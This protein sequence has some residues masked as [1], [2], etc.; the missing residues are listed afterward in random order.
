MSYFQFLGRNVRWLFGGFLLT[1][2][3]SFGQTFFISLSGG[4]IRQE[5]GLSNGEWGLSYMAA[6]LASALTLPFFGRI[7]DV[8]SVSKTILIVVPALAL[9]CF[10]MGISQSILLLV[11]IIYAL[12][13]FGQGMLTHISMTAM[14]RWYSA[15][16]GRAVSVAVVGH[17]GGEALLPIVF[18]FA[19]IVMGW[20]DVWISSAVLLL[21]VALPLTYWLMRVER[22][23]SAGEHSNVNTRDARNWTRTEVLRDPLFYGLLVAVLAPSFIGTTLFFHQ[24]YLIEL[25]SWDKLQYSYSFTIMA[26]MTFIFALIAGQLVDRFSAIRLL[27]AFLIPLAASCFAMWAIEPIWGS[28]VF[29]ALMGVSYGF[30]S[31]LFGALWPEVYGTRHLGAIRAIT[32][33]FMVFGTALG[34][35]VTGYLIDF[36]ISYPLQIFVMGIYCLAASAIMLFVSRR[37]EQRK[38]AEQAA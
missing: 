26:F 2:F 12:R 35:G 18:V 8:L 29:M 3:S 17:Q 33:A 30:S 1:F 32:I 15:Q 21:F 28:Y 7:V 16:R 23:P 22:V 36:G 38:L 24:D 11:V 9:A 34:P 25:R 37:I 27:P 14:G 6:T 5:Y 31:T 20:R 19:L 4:A 10:A 13:L